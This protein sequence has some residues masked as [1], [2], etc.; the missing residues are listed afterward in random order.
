V[1][2]LGLGLGLG[3][4]LDTMVEVHDFRWEVNFS[5]SAPIVNVLKYRADFR[6]VTAP[7]M[8]HTIL[9]RQVR[10]DSAY[11]RW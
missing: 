1:L 10:F 9:L 3:L 5:G 7:L 8:Q 11:F 2:R 6:H 4:G